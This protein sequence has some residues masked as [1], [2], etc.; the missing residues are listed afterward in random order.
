MGAGVAQP[1]AAAGP[2]LQDA[3]L[4]VGEYPQV[5]VGGN[6]PQVMVVE[7][8]E[9]QCMTEGSLEIELVQPVLGV[10]AIV[11]SV[12]APAERL[13]VGVGVVGVGTEVDFVLVVPAASAA[14]GAVPVVVAGV[15]VDFGDDTVA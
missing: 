15:A 6:G 5:V 14:A 10:W 4:G 2:H 9:R 13:V 1:L 12:A 8:E 7:I 3:A 11:C